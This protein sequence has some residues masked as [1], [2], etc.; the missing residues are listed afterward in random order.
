LLN[1]D[2]RYFLSAAAQMRGMQHINPRAAILRNTDSALIAIGEHAG[3]MQAAV[4][5]TTAT[6]EVALNL[7][8]ML[9]GMIGMAM[10]N[11]EGNPGMAAIAKAAAVSLNDAVLSVSLEMPIADMIEQIEAMKASKRGR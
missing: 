1:I 3:M 6:P 8:K 7:S 9:D 2:D 4:E 10:L 11:A 5:M